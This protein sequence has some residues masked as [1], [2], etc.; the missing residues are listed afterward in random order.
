MNFKTILAI[1]LI[2]SVLWVPTG[3]ATKTF[4]DEPVLDTDSVNEVG[5]RVAF[6]FRETTED[7]NTFKNFKP[8]SQTATVTST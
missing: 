3:Y 4:A 1:S 6:H 5:L 8:F 2:A 7:V